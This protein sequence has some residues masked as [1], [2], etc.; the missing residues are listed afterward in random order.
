MVNRVDIHLHFICNFAFVCNAFDEKSDKKWEI[1]MQRPAQS[2]NEEA[3]VRSEAPS[4]GFPSGRPDAG[5][6]GAG[7]GSRSLV[8][9]THPSGCAGSPRAANNVD[10]A[11]NESG[12][13]LTSH[14]FGEP[15]AVWG[16]KSSIQQNSCEGGGGAAAHCLWTHGHPSQW[17]AL[18]PFRLREVHDPPGHE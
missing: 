10:V 15:L 6:I 9:R 8:A 5:Q 2:I 16:T 18:G 11:D 17:R 7:Q 13:Y 14:F 3:M 4:W 1:R 12:F